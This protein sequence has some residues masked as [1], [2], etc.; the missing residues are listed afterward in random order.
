MLI[1]SLILI[2]LKFQYNQ[3]YI[4]FLIAISH[5]F[6]RKA[7]AIVLADCLSYITLRFTKKLIITSSHWPILIH[8][9]FLDQIYFHISDITCLARS[10]FSLSELYFCDH[11]LLTAAQYFSCIFKTIFILAYKFAMIAL[12]V[13]IMSAIFG[14]RFD[15]SKNFIIIQWI[16]PWNRL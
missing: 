2:L 5:L 15:Y 10:N 14:M 16:L 11:Y 9:C 1:I 3:T 6:S 4:I 12:K 7:S 8:L 13:S